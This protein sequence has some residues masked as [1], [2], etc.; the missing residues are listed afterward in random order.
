MRAPAGVELAARYRREHVV[1]TTRA[2]LEDVRRAAVDGG[3]VPP[4]GDILD[5]VRRRLETGAS[6][7]LMR[8]INATGVVLHTNLGRALLADE[9]IAAVVDAARGAVNLEFD[10]ASGR[11]GDR[12]A[13]LA[14]D[15]R[16][17]TGAEASLVVNNN[18][19]AVLLM[20]DTLARGR[21]VVVSR[22]ELIEIGGAFRMPDIMERSG[23]RLREVGTTNRTHA[24]DYRHAIGPDTA[25]LL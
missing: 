21:E 15:L 14:D 13:L 1:E 16:A 6:P 12:D 18:A 11:R 9:A 7:R 10:L 25:L 17:V 19:A 5:R 20:L 8:V 2:V 4:D 23:A 3:D 22:G 24:D